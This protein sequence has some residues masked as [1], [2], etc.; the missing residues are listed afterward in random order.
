MQPA[1]VNIIL[2][3]DQIAGTVSRQA[4]MKTSAIFL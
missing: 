1:P 4:G 3:L 2:R